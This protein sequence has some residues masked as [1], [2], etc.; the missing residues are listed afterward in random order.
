MRTTELAALAEEC[1]VVDATLASVPAEAWTGP[2]LGEWTLHELAAHLT[3]GIS[4]LTE[5]VG[6]SPK[7]DG[8]EHDRVSYFRY[9]A[10][11]VAPAVAARAREAARALSADD[12]PRAFHDGWTTAVAHV[13]EH[14][15]GLL[16]PTPFGTMRAQ[17]YVATRVLEAVVHHMDIRLA[18]ARPPAPTPAAAKLTMQI[19]EGLLDGPRPRNFGRNRFI[20][21]ATGRIAVDDPRFPVL[22]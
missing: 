2:G 7:S 8:V 5:Y 21:A 6:T 15:P 13:E 19:L 18:L 22:G 17:E 11:T 16:V 20:L 4:R 3:R 1:A 10:D 14:D 12:L 9:D